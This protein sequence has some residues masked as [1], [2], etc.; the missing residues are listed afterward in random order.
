MDNEEQ[1]TD[2]KKVW[3]RVGASVLTGVFIIIAGF[4][5][6]LLGL[7]LHVC[8]ST[9]FHT[10]RFSYDNNIISTQAVIDGKTAVAPYL[11][12]SVTDHNG[13]E[14]DFVGWTQDGETIVDPNTITVTDNANYAAMFK[15]TGYVVAGD[16]PLTLINGKDATGNIWQHNGNVY[17]SSWSGQYKLADDGA[18]WVPQTWTGL[19][20][21]D[22]SYIWQH[23]GNVYYSDGNH[24]YKLADDD[25]WVEQSWTGLAL[26]RFYGSYIWQLGDDVYYSFGDQQYKLADDDTWV[27]QSWTGLDLASFYSNNIWQLGDDVYYS[28]GGKHY[29]LADDDTWVEQTW[30]GFTN[31]Y[32]YGVFTVNGETY[33]I[34]DS[35]LQKLYRL[36]GNEWQQ[37]SLKTNVLGKAQCLTIDGESFLA[38][39]GVKYE[40]KD[41]YYCPEA[42][43]DNDYVNDHGLEDFGN[44]WVG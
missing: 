25:T 24:Q 31:F 29:K 18:T 43:V 21:V 9:S 32:G 36:V 6:L 23:N 34:T 35:S 28:Y 37:V 22:S 38:Y 4:M 41:I 44:L 26:A 17:Y 1:T 11:P 2:K 5:G 20:D 39:K 8:M 12:S 30:T 19:T 40:L 33:V 15:F 13:Y 7:S 3:K 27:E 14:Y 10:V 42:N 16:A